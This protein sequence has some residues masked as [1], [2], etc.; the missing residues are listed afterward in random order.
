LPVALGIYLPIHLSAGILVGGII[1]V[2]V[3]KRY[4]N[5]ETELKEKTEKGILLASGLVAGDAIMGIVVAVLAAVGLGEVVGIG[6]RFMPAVAGSNWTSTVV[7][8]LL[9]V[10]IYKFTVKKNKEA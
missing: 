4:K 6:P 5:K 3:D 8:L 1:R 9:A 10:W 2:I 7:Y